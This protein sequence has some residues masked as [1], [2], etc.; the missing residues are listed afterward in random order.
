MFNFCAWEAPDSNYSEHSG[1][2]DRVLFVILLSTTMQI[3][4]SYFL[5]HDGLF[6]NPSN[7][8]FTSHPN[9]AAI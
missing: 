2:T 9:T 5:V 3:P 7:S 8:S 6:Q 1:Y 4:G